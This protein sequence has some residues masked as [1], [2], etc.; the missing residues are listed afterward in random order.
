MGRNFFCAGSSRNRL[1]RK[2]GN[3]CSDVKVLVPAATPGAFAVKEVISISS[4]KPRK[5][6]KKEKIRLVDNGRESERYNKWRCAVLSRDSYKCVLCESTARIEAHHITRWVDDDKNRFN[7]KNGVA[8]CY[9]C[10]QKHHNY[11]KEPFP[12]KITSILYKYI[13]FR[14]DRARLNKVP[15]ETITEYNAFQAVNSR[16][17][18][19]VPG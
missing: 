10:H 9:D 5:K 17:N 14:Y 8:L 16:T 6:Q 1:W 2:P 19:N 18:K 4:I 15:R 7:Q 11:N 12:I 3:K 13:D